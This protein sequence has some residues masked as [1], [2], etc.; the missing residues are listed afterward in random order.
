MKRLLIVLTVAAVGAGVVCATG[1]M[2]PPATAFQIEGSNLL[3]DRS[4]EFRWEYGPASNQI[5]VQ[6]TRNQV[7]AIEV[8]SE[9]VIRVYPNSV[10]S[11]LMFRIGSP[12][13]IRMATFRD[14]VN[15]NQGRK[16]F[17]VVDC[18]DPFED[19]E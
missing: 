10:S 18:G 15:A 5:T 16:L 4:D 3:Y 9:N 7:F 6:T 12:E 2:E 11:F 8:V 14:C 17:E 19:S 13:Y 1:G